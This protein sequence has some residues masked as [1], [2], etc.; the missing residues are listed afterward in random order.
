MTF[1]GPSLC[2]DLIRVG[3]HDLL[4]KWGA[5]SDTA[6]PDL[7]LCIRIW[8]PGN[9]SRT[10][11]EFLG[12]FLGKLSAP[13][14]VPV[15]LGT[16]LGTFLGTCSGTF[17]GFLV[18]HPRFSA[19]FL[20]NKFR[21]SWKRS[22]ERSWVGGYLPGDVPGYLETFLRTCLVTFLWSG[23]VLRNVPEFL[24][25]LLRTSS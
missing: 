4:P 8:V 23:N 9:V 3:G 14:N 18:R 20:K 25:T 24:G 2:L 5:S 21:C 10:S 7:N 1:W 11:A 15:A 19:P 13:R 12:T 22:Y 6:G 16:F 17:P